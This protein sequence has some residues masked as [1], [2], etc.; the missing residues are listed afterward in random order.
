MRVLSKVGGS[1]TLAASTTSTISSFN[2]LTLAQQDVPIN[3][4][5]TGSGNLIITGV[6][7]GNL[8]NGG[9]AINVAT[10]YTGN[11]TVSSGALRLNASGA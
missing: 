11:T 6:Q 3:E 9:V 10:N 1:I 7:A 5:I 8:N 2:R 4:N